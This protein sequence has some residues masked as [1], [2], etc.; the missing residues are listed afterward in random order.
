[1]KQVFLGGPAG[2]TVRD[3]PVPALGPYDVLVRTSHSLIST[4][5]EG[6]SVISSARKARSPL[7]RVTDDPALVA[8]AFKRLMTDG[9][10]STAAA[11]SA[12]GSP[13]LIAIG[14][15]A[16]GIVLEAG[17]SVRDHSPGDRVACAGGGYAN[18]AEYLAVPGNLIVPVPDGLGLDAAAFVTMGAIAMQGVR[19]ADVRL[20]DRVAVVG[21]GLL[22]QL[23]TQLTACAGGRVIAMDLDEDRV[24]LAEELGATA[25]L[26]SSEAD[27]VKAAMRFSDGV[28]LDAVLLFAGTK[29]SEL[30]NQAFEMTRERGRVVVVGDVGMDLERKTFYRREQDL[31]ISRS[32]GPGRYD[33]EY[34][35]HGRD[36]PI[37]YVRWTENRNMRE[38]IELT[39]EGRVEVEPLVAGV[40]PVEQAAEA[41]ETAL[42]ATGTAVATLLTY[43]D[44][45]A[46]SAVDRSILKP[47]ARTVT[48][49][50]AAA[51]RKDDIELGLIGGGSFARNVTI[52][53]AE[54]IDG[55]RIAAVAARTGPS[56]INAAKHAKAR[57]ATSDVDELL[58]DRTID[59][60]LITTRHDSHANLSVRAALAGKHV[61]VEK[62]LGLTAEECRS[63][64][65][66]VSQTGV[67][68]TIGFNRRFSPHIAHAVNALARTAGPKM[69][70]Y[71][72]N[73]GFK[74]ADHWVFDPVE[75]GGRIVG[76]ACH[77]IDLLT[78]L[79]ECEPI[80][81]SAAS[82]KNMGPEYVPLDTMTIC[83]EFADGS[84]GQILYAGSGDPGFAKERLEIYADRTVVCVDDYRT[85]TLYGVPT[86]R[87]LETK[88]A[89]KGHA[90]CLKAFVDAV[91]GR[92]TLSVDVRDGA[93]GTLV[94]LAAVEAARTGAPVDLTPSWLE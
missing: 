24:A 61:F 82:P 29:S 77:F 75:G 89:D 47:D 15:S 38:F 12:G 43:H 68:G 22:G 26:I 80:R 90:A 59:A 63:V 74:P 11:V 25:G 21:L 34:E 88:T 32:Y 69:M 13:D 48:L 79:A 76:E 91:A 18:H 51:N 30:V 62:P 23:G 72:V 16:S 52:P 31:L 67:I 94:A 70:L 49:A 60:V 71:R 85:T 87:P 19:R 1:V 10:R 46:Q 44:A 35:E 50:H 5:T 58:S 65:D 57:T 92:S 64:V 39:A 28:G 2:A 7:Q 42:S 40:F 84:V 83:L 81:V 8:K 55:A 36:Y 45:E 86:G 17:E 27:P 93:R 4:G 6:A 53:A 41:Y 73:A 33:R 66:A 37:A 54:A 3:V 14:Y 20:G 78:Y 9:P 56:A